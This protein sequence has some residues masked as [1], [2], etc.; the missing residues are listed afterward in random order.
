MLGGIVPG[1]LNVFRHVGLAIHRQ[2]RGEIGHDARTKEQS[3]GFE[4]WQQRPSSFVIAPENAPDAIRRVLTVC[5]I[6]R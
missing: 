6:G 3:R 4:T 5:R 2:A 1:S